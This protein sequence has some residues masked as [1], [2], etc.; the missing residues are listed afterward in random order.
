[1]A[2]PSLGH[3]HRPPFPAG[4]ILLSRLRY[5]LGMVL[6]R[7][8]GAFVVAGSLALAGLALGT[9]QALAQG[10]PGRVIHRVNPLLPPGVTVAPGEPIDCKVLFDVGPGGRP[11]QVAITGCPTAFRDAAEAAAWQWHFA[12]AFVGTQ[13]TAYPFTAFLRFQHT[14]R[15]GTASRAGHM[16]ATPSPG[17]LQI[18]KRVLPRM[19]AN[20]GSRIVAYDKKEI[21]TRVRI[22]VDAKGVPYDAQVLEGPWDL[23]DSL[24]KA[25]MQ[26]RFGTVEV[27]GHAVS[28]SYM[29]LQTYATL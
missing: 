3:R 15:R 14:T 26:W 4:L 21:R 1:V 27:Q 28:F 8:L 20:F 11:S 17:K 16:G 2:L 9:P 24:H 12:P 22:D 25:A 13:P 6:P 10:A 5:H 19:P 18:T 23:H 7:A 29:W